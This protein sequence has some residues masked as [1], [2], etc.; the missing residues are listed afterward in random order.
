MIQPKVQDLRKIV[1]VLHHKESRKYVSLEELSSWVGLYPDT[2]GAEL[3]Y[4]EPMIL[5]DSHLNM[6]DLLVPIEAYLNKKKAKK[7][8]KPKA[9]R[10]MIASKEVS[11]YSSITDFVYQRMTSAGGLVDPSNRLSDHDLLLLKKLVAREI[12]M[13]KDTKKKSKGL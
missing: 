1:S 2:L 6:K 11:S 13:R 8:A 4:F 9:K 10:V 7:K 5:M 12:K 3:V